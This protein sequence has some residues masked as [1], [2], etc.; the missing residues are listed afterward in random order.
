MKKNV[1]LFLFLLLYGLIYQGMAQA[2]KEIALVI[3]VQGVAQVKSGDGDW[4]TLKNGRR[5]HSG[6]FIKTEKDALVAFVFTDDK[7]M[8]KIRSQS[9][10]QLNGERDQKGIKKTLLMT[11]GQI[12]SKINPKGAGYKMVTPS[13]VAAVRG[14]EFYG[15]VDVSGKTTIIGISGLVVLYNKVD[16]VLVTAGKT[17]TIE[18]DKAPILADTRGFTPWAETDDTADT[19]DIEFEDANGVRKKLRLK[20]QE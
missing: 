1:Y 16:S 12:W 6:D 5:L 18:K 19:L 9:Q 13:G 3:K 4:Q 11:L 17:A 20:Y 10:I 2:A 14:T 7:S 8:V 15:D